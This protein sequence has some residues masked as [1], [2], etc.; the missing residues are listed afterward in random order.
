MIK[1]KVVKKVANK[2]KAKTNL[3]TVRRVFSGIDQGDKYWKPKQ[4]KNIIR[5][6][7]S[8]REDGNFAFHSIQHHGFKVDGKNRAY[9][10]MLS[11]KK[12]CPV[13][14]VIAYHDTD[15]DPD[16]Q[17]ALKLIGA[18][19][20][21]LMNVIDRGVND[22]KVKIYAAPKTVMTEIYHFVSDDDYGD[23]TDEDEGHDV[24][25][26]RTGEM[27]ATRYSTRVSPK[28]SPIGVDGWE[29]QLFNLEKEAYREV[30]S[31]KKY[32]ELLEDNFG[33]VLQVQV[34]LGNEEADEEEDE[35][36]EEPK[37]K[38]KVVKGKKPVVK[39]KKVTK[40][41]DEDWD[42]EDDED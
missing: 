5:I 3:D 19:H 20:Q 16:V 9:P 26:D 12:P 27:L 4:G 29:D 8:N 32:E 24:K 38:K 15:T 23:I 17:E 39:K 31:T 22:G 33:N 42:D 18:R 35:E 2:S 34:A 21:F 37:P 7:P 25:I 30:P 41:E 11:F 1:K 13:C 14:K 6:L 40:I 10:C 36:E 28:T